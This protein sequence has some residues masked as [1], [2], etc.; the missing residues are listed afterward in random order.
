[1]RMA[2]RSHIGQIKEC[3]KGHGCERHLFAL[4]GMWGRTN[5][6]TLERDRMMSVQASV[7]R[8]WR[9]CDVTEEE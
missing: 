3:A 5:K 7:W 4:K 2:I 9:G 1:M 6:D 8:H